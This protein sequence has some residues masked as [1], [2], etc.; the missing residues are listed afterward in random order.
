MSGWKDPKVVA[1][2]A[3]LVASTAALIVSISALRKKPDD[4]NINNNMNGM[5]KVLVEAVERL[6][7]ESEQNRADIYRIRKYMDEY[8]KS[9]SIIGIV[10]EPPPSVEPSKP[11]IQVEPSRPKSADAGIIAIAPMTS[12]SSSYDSMHL[13][14]KKSEPPI[15][16]EREWKTSK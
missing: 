4:T 15:K 12:S 3:G 11:I 9:Q 14:S 13:V 1:A 16:L 6:S 8:I 2:Y 10:S 7:D 5:Y